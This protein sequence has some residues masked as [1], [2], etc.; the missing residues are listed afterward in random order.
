M[1]GDI[2]PTPKDGVDDHLPKLYYMCRQ[3]YTWVFGLVYCMPASST[4]TGIKD[5][6]EAGMRWGNT[7]LIGG[8]WANT[9]LVV[10]VSIPGYISLPHIRQ[11]WVLDPIPGPART[12]KSWHQAKGVYTHIKYAYMW[13]I[14]TR[15]CMYRCTSGLVPMLQLWNQLE[16]IRSLW[17][18]DLVNSSGEEN[19]SRWDLYTWTFCTSYTLHSCCIISNVPKNNESAC[20][21][22]PSQNKKPF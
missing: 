13:T 21:W 9:S 15:I 8:I 17:G 1:H 20:L 4:N 16:T 2:P 5:P 14:G 11:K 7:S 10:P 6:C 19:A 12:C 18:L 3:R 22:Q